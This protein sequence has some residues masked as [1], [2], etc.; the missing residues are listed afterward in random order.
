[1]ELN[2]AIDRA[3]QSEQLVEENLWKG[4]LKQ[5]MKGDE[6]QMEYQKNRDKGKKQKVN[7]NMDEM[8]WYVQESTEESNM[9][10]CMKVNSSWKRDWKN[11]T[12]KKWRRVSH[13][14][15]RNTRTHERNEVKM[16]KE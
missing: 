4:W 10:Q 13:G 11:I 2:I 14:K 5:G 3:L 12:L 16:N 7:E 15:E 9:K 6:S 1:M 8:K